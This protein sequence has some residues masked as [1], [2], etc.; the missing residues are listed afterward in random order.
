M[1]APAPY[2]N[3]AESVSEEE[4]GF[5]KSVSR[6]KIPLQDLKSFQAEGS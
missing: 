5:S 6:R 1:I 3:S 4:F 2:D